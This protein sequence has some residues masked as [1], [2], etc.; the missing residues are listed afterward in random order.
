MGDVCEIIDIIY[1]CNSLP[2]GGRC[3]NLYCMSVICFSCTVNVNIE[4]TCYKD[5]QIDQKELINHV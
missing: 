2:K 4:E 3:I 1:Y 5:S